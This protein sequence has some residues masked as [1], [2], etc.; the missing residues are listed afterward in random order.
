M[1]KKKEPSERDSVYFL[2]LTLYLIIGAQ[3]LWLVDPQTGGQ[4]PIP[5]GLL[6]GIVFAAHDHFQIDRKIELAVLLAAMLVGFF[7]HVG[8]YIVM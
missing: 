8:I 4:L 1:A 7:A 3:W 6:A 5:V 2:K